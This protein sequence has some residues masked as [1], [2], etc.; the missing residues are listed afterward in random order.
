MTDLIV[1][2]VVAG[3]IAAAVLLS[4]KGTSPAKGSAKTSS[5]TGEPKAAELSVE[6]TVIDVATHEAEVAAARAQ[7]G[8]D[9]ARALFRLG[10]AQARAG[11][12]EKA[13]ETLR[14][15]IAETLPPGQAAYR[16]H[17][18]STLAELCARAGL[19]D[20]AERHLR[21]VLPLR[22]ELSG[23]LHPDYARALTPLVKVLLA[24]GTFAE[25]AKIADEAA[26]ALGAT[27]HEETER[28]Q[29]AAA[30]AHLLLGEP[31]P[32][33]ERVSADRFEP[34]VTGVLDM[35]SVLHPRAVDHVVQHSLP[36]LDGRGLSRSVLAIQLLDRRAQ[37]QRLLGQPLEASKSLA[38]L[39][40]IADDHDRDEI[41][42]PALLTRAILL[43]EA[44][45]LD[46]AR[47]AYDNLTEE[48]LRSPNDVRARILREKGLF[49]TRFDSTSSL[50]ALDE[51]LSLAR[52]GGNDEV[53][54]ACLLAAGV[55]H[56][57]AGHGAEAKALLDEAT[58]HFAEGHPEHATLVDHIAS[59]ANGAPCACRR[60][61]Q[62]EQSVNAAVQKALSPELVRVRLQSG[63]QGQTFQ[64]EFSRQPSQAE[65]EMAKGAL[66]EAVRKLRPSAPNAA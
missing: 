30:V 26:A 13:V 29:G 7:G 45:Q 60:R 8:L 35:L 37:A 4:K 11:E 52:T 42:L 55:W 47:E 62:V 2:G 65:F 34:F 66:E 25:A 59:A 1:L 9:L 61:A 5:E 16:I 21:D 38:M 32:N 50:A 57:H 44:G 39:A 3:L 10:V 43:V 17:H 33:I 6:E 15:C 14:T 58:P 51:A 22:E 64:L 63:P 23:R 31:V 46:A 20:D 28:A 19:L 53:L 48:T 24:K 18:L 54:G 56:L 49:L 40:D 41:V 36:L 12:A 27:R